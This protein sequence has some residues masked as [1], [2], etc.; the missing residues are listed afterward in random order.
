MHNTT[1]FDV[2][3]IGGGLA[4]LTAALHLSQNNIKVL[5]IEKYKFP[6][7][8]VCGEYVSNEVLPYLNNLG[9]FPLTHGAKSITQFQ[10]T[11]NAGKSIKTQLPMG[12]F[13]M[14]RFTLDM[15]LFEKASKT[16]QFLI[17]TVIDINF[18]SEIFRVETSGNKKYTSSYI[19]GA[20]GKRSN[21]DIKLNRNF[22]KQK[23][24][25]LGVKAH[26]EYDMPNN[27]VALHN[28][29]GGYCG[30][31]K[32]ETNAVNACYLTT[33]NSF[34]KHG[35]IDTF[36]KKELSKNPHLNH[37]FNNSKMLFEKPLTISQVS[38][39]NKKLVENHIVMIGD[40]AGLIHPLCG[41]GMA[42]AIHSAK[43]FS[44]IFIKF[45][46]LKTRD[47]IEKTY[48]QQ[49]EKTFS[50]R[51]KTGSLIQ[52]V[53]LKPTLANTVFKAAKLAPS[54]L[55]HIIKRTHGNVTI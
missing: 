7:H 54:I 36:Q 26:Y 31:S 34:K 39:Q 47:F 30:L 22:I 8:K 11:T 13:G 51:L 35:D 12:G 43:L 32:T 38:F 33:F 10:I 50:N 52:R 19:L 16:S 40:S 29:N 49:W 2:I 1:D 45:K 37:F 3:I 14:S 44:E 25:W 42:M 6:H 24:P 21:L 28:F 23:S 5:V 20:F 48:T 27:K 17:D 41:N 9:I 55:Q 4:G 15:L 53:L 18:S 46:D